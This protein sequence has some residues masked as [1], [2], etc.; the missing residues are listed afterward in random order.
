MSVKYNLGVVRF[1]KLAARLSAFWSQ[2]FDEYHHFEI[3]PKINK[4]NSNDQNTNR[5]SI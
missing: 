1:V 5:I 2:T 4:L 3:T